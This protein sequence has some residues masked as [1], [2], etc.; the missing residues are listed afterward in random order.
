M[1][2]QVEN[3]NW[4]GQAREAVRGRVCKRPRLKNLKLIALVFALLTVASRA[5]AQGYN[6]GG[7]G[8]GGGSTGGSGSITGGGCAA[9]K[10]TTSINSSGVPTCAQPSASQVTGLAPSATTDTT[11]ASNIASGTLPAG[12]LP[13]VPSSDISGLAAS[14]TTDT[15]N[16]SN[17]SAGTLNSARLPGGIPSSASNGVAIASGVMQQSQTVYYAIDH[18]MKCDGS[19]NDATALASLLTAA[20][21]NCV[22][23]SNIATKQ[24]VID[25]PAG[26]RCVVNSGV[27]IDTSCTLVRGNGASLDFSGMPSSGTAITTASQNQTTPYNG[28][29]RNL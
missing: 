16:A 7:Y 26:A 6:N 21:A 14:A 1:R 18:G 19:T 5:Q 15:T 10:Y 28:Q 24:A 20:K 13:T 3:L 2:K 9:N 17:I 8:G 11:N 23:S 12:Q 25:L 29:H 22:M 27:T 4:I